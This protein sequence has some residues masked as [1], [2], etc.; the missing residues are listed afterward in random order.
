[1]R[2]FSETCG[3]SNVGCGSSGLGKF[4]PP[5]NSIPIPTCQTPQQS[6]PVHEEINLLDRSL[7]NMSELLV[8]L[9]SKLSVLYNTPTS[10]SELKECDVACVGSS[11]LSNRI[12]I[13]MKLSYVQNLLL[14]DI[15]SRLEI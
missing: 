14:N 6:Y 12:H 9:D 10:T 2:D 7:K 5:K 8:A 4:A 15:I 13:L 11:E 3:R 1:M